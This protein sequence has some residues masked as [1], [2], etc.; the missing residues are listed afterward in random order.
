MLRPAVDST[1]V[2][3]GEENGSSLE[4]LAGAVCVF[5]NRI[6]LGVELFGSKNRR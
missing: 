3:H 1:L 5:R 6:R 4:A 2:D